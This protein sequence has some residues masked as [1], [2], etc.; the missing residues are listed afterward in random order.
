MQNT[1]KALIR[2]QCVKEMGQFVSCAYFLLQIP[3]RM[4]FNI[5]DDVYLVRSGTKAVT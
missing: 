1:H 5:I 3:V 4:S 2:A